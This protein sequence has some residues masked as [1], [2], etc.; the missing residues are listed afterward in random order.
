M[1]EYPGEKY[2]LM[3]ASSVMYNAVCELRLG[4]QD[5]TKSFVENH[6]SKHLSFPFHVDFSSD[7]TIWVKR[8]VSCKKQEDSLSFREHLNSPPVSWWGSYCSCLFFYFWFC[9]GFFVF[10]LFLFVCLFFF[11]L[12]PVACVPNVASSS[13]LA[14]LDCLFG[15]LYPLFI[16]NHNS[17][18]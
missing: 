11:Y 9:L 6:L 10:C 14:I 5:V 16:P 4:V 2:M 12:R 7:L 3:C 8:Q 15:F 13:G 17:M 1:H 18:I